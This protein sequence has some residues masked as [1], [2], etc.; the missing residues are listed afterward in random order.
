MG[1]LSWIQGKGPGRAAVVGS[2]SGKR[3]GS[4]SGPGSGEGGTPQANM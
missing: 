1:L 2:G 3:N 4:F